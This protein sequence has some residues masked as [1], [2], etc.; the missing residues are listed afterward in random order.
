MISKELA[1]NNASTQSQDYKD[2]LEAAANEREHFVE[3]VSIAHEAGATQLEIA[4]ATDYSRQ[5][6][7]QFLRE[8]DMEAIAQRFGVT[9]KEVAAAMNGKFADDRADGIR[10][11]AEEMG[12]KVKNVPANAVA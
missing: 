5:R 7:A 6:I 1:L 3:K 12:Y 8:V 9:V 10:A 11:V 2:A 4:E